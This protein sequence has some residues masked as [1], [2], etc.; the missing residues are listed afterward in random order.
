[1]S[2]KLI[3]LNPDLKKLQDQGFEIEIKGAYLLVHSV[4]Y[5]NSHQKIGLGTLVSPLDLAGD[6]TVKPK[7]H[8]IQFTGEHPCNKDG[9]IITAIQ[10]ASQKTALGDDI[11]IDHTFSAK[12]A[13]GY[14]DYYDKVTTYVNIISSQ[15]EAIDPSVT[16]KTFK[17]IESDD[18]EL[19]FNYNDTNS[20]RAEINALSAKLKHLKIAIIGLGGTGSYVLDFV[21][22][23][24]VQEIHL[25]DGDEFLQHNAF[26]S[27]GAAAIEKLREQPKKVV[28]LRQVYSQ[29][30]KNVVAHEV[31]LTSSNVDEISGMGF[32]FVCV[33]H[34]VGRNIIDE[35]LIER[36]IPFVDVGMGVDIVDG[37]LTGGV[38]ITT[39]TGSKTD[40]VGA[41]IPFSDGGN[42]DYSKN[43]QIAELNALNAALAVIKWKKMFG[44]YHDME[45]E[46]HT[47]YEINL[48]TLINDEIGS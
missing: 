30:R 21:A 29:M 19:V 41:R 28:Y 33:D 1:M 44:F 9:S 36:K 37:L 24:P 7:S 38:R 17:P 16:A 45:K 15:A 23:T 34:G 18:P 43:I 40:H 25:F 35:K 3:N 31:H 26:R 47:V 6:V 32:V 4:P 12:P 46:L 5:V 2:R 42:D 11:E 48:N 27:P 14:N 39:C 10:N 20:S 8:V 13:N 22:K